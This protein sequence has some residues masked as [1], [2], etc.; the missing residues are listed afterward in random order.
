MVRKEDVRLL[1]L[2]NIKKQGPDIHS[3]PETTRKPDT[4]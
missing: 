1:L 2:I 4:I 3:P